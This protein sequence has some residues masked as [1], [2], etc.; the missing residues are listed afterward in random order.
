MGSVQGKQP[1]SGPSTGSAA[2]TLGSSSCASG[3]SSSSNSSSSNSSSSSSDG[4]SSSSSSSTKAPP[5]RPASTLGLEHDGPRYPGSVV[6]NYVR[7]AVQDY[8]ARRPSASPAEPSALYRW[9]VRYE[10]AILAGVF[11]A[12]MAKI[13][14]DIWVRERF[15]EG[16]RKAQLEVQH[17]ERWS[18]ARERVDHA[19]QSL[20]VYQSVLRVSEA[21]YK[22]QARA[23]A[24]RRDAVRALLG[25]AGG[26]GAARAAAEGAASERG[27]SGEQRGR[28]AAALLVALSATADSLAHHAA[29]REAAGGKVKELGERLSA[30]EREE[31]EAAL[32][33]RDWR[34]YSPR[35]LI[36]EFSTSTDSSAESGAASASPQPGVGG[37]R[38][39]RLRCWWPRWEAFDGGDD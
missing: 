23:L 27:D 7:T 2:A 33:L 26:A 32:L 37:G 31:A 10:G 20:E 1:G 16:A 14:V 4:G 28:Q 11:V 38:S 35:V 3:I 34:A 8:R 9:W 39:T 12:W 24:R 13:S 36:A 15:E 22:D 25:D 19:R 6:S 17:A 18:A 5:S 30:E 29:M 21:R